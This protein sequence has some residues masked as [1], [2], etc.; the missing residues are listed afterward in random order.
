[1]NPQT[2]HSGT[3]I[4]LSKNSPSYSFVADDNRTEN[5]G[6]VVMNVA[7]D[8]FGN[9]ISGSLT[10]EYGFSTKPLVDG[11][12][13]YYYG[14]RYY[15][16][17]TG[18]W[19]SRDPIGEYGGLNL[20]GMV[21]NNPIRWIDYLGLSCCGGSQL[22]SGKQCCRD[23]QISTSKDC[24]SK[25]D[26]R[27]KADDAYHDCLDNC[28]AARNIIVGQGVVIGGAISASGVGVG[29]GIGWAGY[30]ALKGMLVYKA[31]TKRCKKRWDTDKRKCNKCGLS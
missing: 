6:N 15:D 8:P 10:G 20:Y 28:A 23:Q 1:M 27:D 9:V 11:V 7:Y 18:R 5:V 21:G 30:S 4:M 17:V 22:A 19:P 12:D 3:F 16:P 29:F 13:W 2:N 25:S 31:C 26:C 14:F 24:C